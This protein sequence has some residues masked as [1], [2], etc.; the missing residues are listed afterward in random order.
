MQRILIAVDLTAMDEHLLQYVAWMSRFFDD[1]SEVHLLHN[2]KHSFHE[3][4]VDVLEELEKPLE[5]Y[6]Q[7]DLEE[8]AQKFLTQQAFDVRIWVDEQESTA[9]ALASRANKIGADVLVVGKKIQY[10]GSGITHSR[11]LRLVECPVLLL[12]DVANMKLERILVPVDFSRPAHKAVAYALNMSEDT[13]ASVA[14]QHVY[15]IPKRY[16]PF[17]PVESATESMHAYAQKKYA[18]FIKQFDQD[19]PCTFTP[20]KSKSIIYNIYQH[21]LRD[22]TDLIVIGSKGYTMFIGSV[23]DGLLNMD[24]KIPLMVVKG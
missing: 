7:E 20:G 12:P 23:T 2:I 4:M 11:L 19:I 21:A 14:C 1:V 18:Q 8:K 3:E 17:I 13:Q 10:E 24:M 5:A 6:I 16:F 15:H 9:H 22:R